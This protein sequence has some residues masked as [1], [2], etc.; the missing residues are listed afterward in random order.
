MNEWMNEWMNVVNLA[1][2]TAL[3]MAVHTNILEI[4]VPLVEARANVN[5]IDASGETPFDIGLRFVFVF[6]NDCRQP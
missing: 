3:H 6:N 1:T 5:A 4:V 2:Q